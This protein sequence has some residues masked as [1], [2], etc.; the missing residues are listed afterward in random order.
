MLFTRFLVA[1]KAGL[2]GELAYRCLH[3]GDLALCAIDLTNRIIRQRQI[4]KRIISLLR[5]S[6]T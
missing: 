1:L 5:E 3:L 6:A 4:I 2:I